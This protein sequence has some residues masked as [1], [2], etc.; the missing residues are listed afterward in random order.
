MPTRVFLPL[1]KSSRIN[2]KQ[3]FP[4]SP[5]A[6]DPTSQQPRHQSWESKTGSQNVV[7]EGSFHLK[8]SLLI[9]S[10]GAY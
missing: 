4:L 9:Y 8:C 6:K 7:T 2:R 5:L 1:E 10:T 3:F